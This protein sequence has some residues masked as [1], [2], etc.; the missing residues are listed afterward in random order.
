M[1]ARSDRLDAS[2]MLASRFG[3]GEVRRERFIATREAMRRELSD[4]SGDLLWRYSGMRDCEGTFISCAFWMVEAYGLLGETEEANRLFTSLLARVQNDVGLMP[5]MWDPQQ[6]QGLGN[7]P[8]G[9]SHL[10]LVHAALAL[11]GE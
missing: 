3:L 7:T 5:E 11:D 4:E 6:E 10:A 2:L 9:L 8:Q 1:P